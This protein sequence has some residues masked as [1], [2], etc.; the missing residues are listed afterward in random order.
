MFLDEIG[1]AELQL[2]GAKLLRVDSGK[3]TFEKVGGTKSI[4]VDVRIIAAT[5][6]ILDDLVR[7][8]SSR[9]PLLSFKRCSH[10]TTLQR[11]QDIPL[12]LNYF[13]ERSNKINDAEIDGCSEAQ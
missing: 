3:K 1:D 6:R 2:Y 8:A 12:L 11:R 5:N 13:L 10:S 7:M 9:R 4:G